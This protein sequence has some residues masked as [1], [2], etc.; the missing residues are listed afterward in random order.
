MPTKILFKRLSRILLFVLFSVYLGF[1]LISLTGC[2]KGNDRL[3]FEQQIDKRSHAVRVLEEK[4]AAKRFKCTSQN[5]INKIIILDTLILGIRKDHN[6]YI[7]RAKINGGCNKKYFAELTCSKD[8]ADQFNE[9]KSNYSILAAKID[10]VLE[11]NV[12]AEVDS[13]GGEESHFNIGNAVLLTG[14]CLALAEVPAIV[15]AN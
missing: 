9:T 3:S 11:S 13:L 4:F 6:D 14:E 2:G 7:I 12:L 5:L 8:V 15:N 1:S 10:K